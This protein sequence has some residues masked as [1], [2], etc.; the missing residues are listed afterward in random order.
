[1]TNLA[2]FDE[3]KKIKPD[4]ALSPDKELQYKWTIIFAYQTISFYL[5]FKVFGM[6][7]NESI[8]YFLMLSICW[9]LRKNPETKESKLGAF[10]LAVQNRLDFMNS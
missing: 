10:I 9:N 8:H 5:W 1:M 7:E 4:N 6:P 3:I 2:D